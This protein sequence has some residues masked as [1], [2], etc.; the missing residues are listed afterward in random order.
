[1]TGIEIAAQGSDGEFGQPQAVSFSEEIFKGRTIY[2][3]GTTTAFSDPGLEL[4]RLANVTVSFSTGQNVRLD[5]PVMSSE[6][7]DFAKAWTTAR[8]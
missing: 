8:G 3:D 5:V 2:L 6:H 4:G 1:M 7:P